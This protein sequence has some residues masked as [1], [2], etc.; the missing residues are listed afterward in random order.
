MLGENPAAR[1]SVRAVAARAGVSAGSL[2]HFFPT[3]Q[4]LVETVVALVYDVDIPGDPILDAE[5]PPAERLVACLQQLLSEVGHG[6]AA[7]R[8]WRTLQD[9]YM[10]GAPTNEAAANYLALERLGLHRIRRWLTTL[11]EEGAVQAESIEPAVRFL[12]TVLSGLVTERALP[13]D[14]ARLE[15]EGTTLRIAADAVLTAG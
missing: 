8:Y 7:R 4:D 9:T 13:A 1:L 12:S 14:A 11:A 6:E 5:R 2:R 3:Q 10:A 15:A